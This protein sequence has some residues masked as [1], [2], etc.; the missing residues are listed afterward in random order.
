VVAVE[1]VAGEVEGVG[2]EAEEVAGAGVLPPLVIATKE[3]LPY[4]RAKR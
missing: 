1:M 3:V 4:Q 2:M